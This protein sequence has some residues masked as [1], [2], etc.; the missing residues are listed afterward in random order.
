MKRLVNINRPIKLLA[1]SYKL[2]Q[3]VVESKRLIIFV[4]LRNRLTARIDKLY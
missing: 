2:E 3:Q 1:A 4:T